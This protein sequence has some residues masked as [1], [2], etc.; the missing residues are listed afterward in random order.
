VAKL[1][2]KERYWRKKRFET[3]NEN[4]IK[5][6]ELIQGIRYALAFYTAL[7]A[8]CGEERTLKSYPKLAKKLGV[9]MYE[10][11]FP[12]AEEFRSCKDPWGAFRKYFLEFF[13][14][15]EREGICR[16]QLIHDTEDEFRVQ[17]S[18]CAFDAMHREAGHPE[19]MAMGAEGDA[20]FLPSL[21]RGVG[22]DFSRDGWLCHGDSVCD[23]HFFRPE[24]P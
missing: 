23:W 10:E 6:Q 8:S 21:G 17:L 7:L 9:M 13:Q 2:S 20:D 18:Y 24:C 12:T 3:I 22:C 15:W 16:F 5:N 1:Q 19:A 14:A 4:G 11:F